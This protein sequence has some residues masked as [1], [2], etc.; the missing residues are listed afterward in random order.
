MYGAC[1]FLCHEGIACSECGVCGKVCCVAEV[2]EVC[3]LF[4][5]GKCECFVMQ[6]L[7]MSCVNHLAVINAVF[8]I[9][10]SLLMLVEDAIIWKNHTPEP[11]S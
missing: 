11:V 2:F 10:C 8:C 4:V 6:L 5:Y 9:T 1:L 7:Y 3:C